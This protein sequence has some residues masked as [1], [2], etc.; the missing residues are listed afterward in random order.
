MERQEG[1]WGNKGR[2]LREGPGENKQLQAKQPKRDL[3][4]KE[5]EE[6]PNK[7]WSLRQNKGKREHMP[8][9]ISP[10]VS[11]VSNTS[12][13]RFLCCVNSS[14]QGKNLSLHSPFRM[15]FLPKQRYF[16]LFPTQ[17]PLYSFFFQGA[18][19]DRLFSNLTPAQAMSQNR[20]QS[21]QFSLSRSRRQPASPVCSQSSSPPSSPVLESHSG[22]P[23]SASVDRHHVPP[24]QTLSSECSSS[25]S[26]SPP[27]LLF[28]LRLPSIST[29]GIGDE[30]CDLSLS[31]SPLSSSS[32][33]SPSRLPSCPLP[34]S[35]EFSPQI[36]SNSLDLDSPSVLGPSQ[37]LEDFSKPRIS[38]SQ[39][40]SGTQSSKGRKRTKQLGEL[41]G[42]GSARS[43]KRRKRQMGPEEASNGSLSEEE[44]QGR[45]ERK[46]CLLNLFDDA[47]VS[48]PSKISKSPA[49]IVKSD[50]E[51]EE[52]G[53]SDNDL[54][55]HDEDNEYILRGR[56]SGMTGPHAL[57]SQKLSQIRPNKSSFRS[58]ESGESLSADSDSDSPPKVPSCLSEESPKEETPSPK[59]PL[60]S[61]SSLPCQEASSP[62]ESPD[63]PLSRAPSSRQLTPS[64][65]ALEPLSPK[66]IP[67]FSPHVSL[68]SLPPKEPLSPKQSLPSQ[69]PSPPKRVLLPKETPPVGSSHV[70]P[71]DLSE[72]EVFKIPAGQPRA[73]S[74]I[75]QKVQQR[76]SSASFRN[77]QSKT[78]ES[79][80][81]N[82][83]EGNL[84][85]NAADSN[86]SN[87]GAVSA[88]IAANLQ[89]ILRLPLPAIETYM[90]VGISELH[91]WQRDC[92]ELANNWDGKL[93][94]EKDEKEKEESEKD[95]HT[96]EPTPQI[97]DPQPAHQLPTPISRSLQPPKLRPGPPVR[98][99]RNFAPP[100][101]QA[102]APHCRTGPPRVN[103][104]TPKHSF[105]KVITNGRMGSTR[106]P[107]RRGPSFEK[108]IAKGSF[109]PQRMNQP[110]NRRSIP[111]QNQNQ[112]F[113]QERN[114]ANPPSSS[115]SNKQNAPSFPPT[116]APVKTP[117]AP[118]VAGSTAPAENQEKKV[119]PPLPPRPLSDVPNL[120][121]QAPTS[122]GKT[123]VAEALMLRRV[124]EK[125]LKAMYVLPFVSVVR[126][127]VYALG[128]VC[129]SLQLEV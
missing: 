46:R 22:V 28:T 38:G 95:A 14:L 101:P 127:K 72:V 91:P 106:A 41:D 36:L 90:S 100:Q 104:N 19:P 87:Q 75:Q 122:S 93:P 126:E 96:N 10:F 79:V 16:F 128:R 103:H 124:V 21:S 25:S 12:Q 129:S 24:S 26:S 9:R 99:A 94:E 117:E 34:S 17:L 44:A 5:R 111:P 43:K 55:P 78:K 45:S 80:E 33:T 8:K 64:L 68:T 77:H 109:D 39:I 83:T 125:K 29:S 63:I 121:Y 37:I 61:S 116:P 53:D 30:E 32:P 70:M 2:K 20:S 3:R 18:L 4:P 40:C 76:L 74:A 112:P 59:E 85:P 113:P 49:D 51:D 114:L 35:L 120:I 119:P 97:S 42:E 67:P 11:K 7:P 69:G 115:N 118:S 71:P 81:K 23:S 92:F 56:L 1:G 50:Q 47:A 107:S 86:P 54:D 58:S 82:P 110:S 15:Y 88:R 52:S 105:D 65:S 27:S 98:P 89:K 84:S 57:F 102:I 108:V 13:P 66:E 73:P 48:S 123:L 6:R 31:S 60:P 62:E